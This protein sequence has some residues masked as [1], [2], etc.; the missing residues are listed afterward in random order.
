MSYMK[1]NC[2]HVRYNIRLKA[3]IFVNYTV[4]SSLLLQ[5]KRLLYCMMRI[6]GK[7]NETDTTAFTI[8]FNCQDI[9]K[10][11]FMTNNNEK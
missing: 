7:G 4:Y 9:S 2:R 10:A 6:Y 8:T 1:Y 5:W 11:L 3:R